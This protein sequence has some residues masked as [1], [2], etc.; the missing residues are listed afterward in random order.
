MRE[1]HPDVLAGF[2]IKRELR[3]RIEEMQ[4]RAMEIVA[5]R[6]SPSGVAIPEVDVMGR[7]RALYLTPG[8]CSRFGNSEL[9]TEI[10]VAITESALDAKRQYFLTMNDSALLPRPLEEVLREWRAERASAV[11]TSSG[12]MKS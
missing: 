12:K 5:R 1:L 10:M 2:A 8:T 9:I 6:P 3:H 4:E 7:L 11:C